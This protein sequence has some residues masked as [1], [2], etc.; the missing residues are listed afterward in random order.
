MLDLVSPW[1]WA[2]NIMTGL[3]IGR[4]ANFVHDFASRSLSPGR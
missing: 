2:G 1:P 4:G 3:I